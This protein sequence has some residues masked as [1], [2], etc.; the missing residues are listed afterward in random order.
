MCISRTRQYFFTKS[1][2][3]SLKALQNEPLVVNNSHTNYPPQ[4]ATLFE[5]LGDISFIY[6][7]DSKDILHKILHDGLAVA[8]GSRRTLPYI[9]KIHIIEIPLNGN[10][11]IESGLIYTP[12]YA[13]DP[14]IRE[15]LSIAK[16][17]YKSYQNTN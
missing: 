10:L 15:F 7:V 3:Y 14:L 17:Y 6:I 12:D 11:Y 9:A 5:H 2:R 16:D 13:D 4:T 1:K 8:I